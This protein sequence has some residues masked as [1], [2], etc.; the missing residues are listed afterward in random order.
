MELCRL[1]VLIILPIFGEKNSQR[2]LHIELGKKLAA[3]P[4][5]ASKNLKKWT[6]I[7]RRIV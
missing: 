5:I 1:S 3:S 7:T 2:S 6:R 4:G